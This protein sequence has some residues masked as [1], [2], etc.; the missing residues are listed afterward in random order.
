MVALAVSGRA[1]L[2]GVGSRTSRATAPSYTFATLQRFH[3]RGYGA[4]RTV[5]RHRRRRV[6]ARST[7]GRTTRAILDARTFRGRVAARS[8]GRAIC[9]QRLP[10]LAS[11]MVRP[12]IVDGAGTK[13]LIFLIDA[14][15]ADVSSTAIRRLR[16]EGRPITGLVDLGVEQHIEQ[17]GLYTSSVPGRR[18][19][20]GP[21]THA[22]GRLHGED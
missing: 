10:Q 4:D 12:P 15:T 17:H 2:A 19:N 5:L 3:E 18:G 9:P 6:C 7:P 13:P 14:P 21:S 20:D 8:S 11:R 22:A 1:R 16:A